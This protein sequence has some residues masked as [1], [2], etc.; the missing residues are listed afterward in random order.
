MHSLTPASSCM[1][2]ANT[3]FPGVWE[4][5]EVRVPVKPLS[6]HS[7]EDTGQVSGLVMALPQR[8]A[9]HTPAGG[10]CLT[11]LHGC[12]GGG[13]EPALL[14]EAHTLLALVP[15]GNGHRVQDATV[16]FRNPDAGAAW[17]ET[18]YEARTH[19]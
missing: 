15:E 14:A 18:N 11:A 8:S 1:L 2:P 16:A 10:L 4:L 3:A 19:S 13:P 9:L 7:H 6:P 17:G 5:E 12:P